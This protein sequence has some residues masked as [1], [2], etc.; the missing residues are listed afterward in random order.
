[1][2]AHCCI[3]LDLFIN[4]NI[5]IFR[6]FKTVTIFAPFLSV[7]PPASFILMFLN[8]YRKSNPGVSHDRM[9]DTLGLILPAR[10]CCRILGELEHIYKAAVGSSS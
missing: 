1:M 8:P 10:P 5:V 4:I 9:T 6:G 7:S 3:K 2:S